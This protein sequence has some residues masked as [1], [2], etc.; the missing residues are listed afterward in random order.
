MIKLENKVKCVTITVRL[1]LR[2]VAESSF[3]RVDGLPIAKLRKAE[4]VYMYLCICVFVYLCIYVFMYLCV[5]LL[6][7]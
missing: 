4:F 6:Q 7:S 5:C 3:T 2:S 1:N